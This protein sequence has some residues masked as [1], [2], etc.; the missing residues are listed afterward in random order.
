MNSWRCKIK[1]CS[2]A[3]LP[4]LLYSWQTLGADVWFVPSVLVI[5]PSTKLH[6]SRW[7]WGRTSEEYTAL[8]GVR[9]APWGCICSWSSRE[10]AL[11]MPLCSARACPVVPGVVGRE[12]IRGPCL[13]LSFKSEGLLSWCVQQVT[14]TFHAPANPGGRCSRSSRSRF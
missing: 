12:W 7:L 5:V 11:W 3:A 8:C 4:C 6:S 10:A 9:S 13:A 1:S 2:R 14:V